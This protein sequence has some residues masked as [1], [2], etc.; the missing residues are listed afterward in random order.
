M[1]AKIILIVTFSAS[2]LFANA[3]V[4]KKIYYN[5]DWKIVKST[6]TVE[7]YRIVK[8]DANNKALDTIRNYYVTGE[9]E[10]K[11][12]GALY[13]DTM[14]EK[15]TKYTGLAR[16]YYKSGKRKYE[17]TR[18]K[19][20]S[21]LS[22]SGWY[23]DGKLR[24]TAPYVNGKEEG[25]EKWYYED[26]SELSE[27]PYVNDKKSGT[28][29]WYYP[30]GAVRSEVIYVNDLQEGTSKGYYPTG[31]LNDE[32]TYVK[33]TLV[34]ISKYYYKNGKLQAEVPHAKGKMDGTYKLYYES[35]KPMG[36][37]DY[38]NGK[39]NGYVILYWEN[40]ILKRR[41]KYEDGKFVEGKCYDSDGLAVQHYDY[42]VEG[43][44]DDIYTI[45]QQMPVFQGNMNEY[46][47]K[48]IKYPKKEQKKGIMGTV[49][50]NFIVEKDG[51]VSNAKVLR[52]VE[53]GPGLEE[54][55]LRVIS[56]MPKWTP[57]IQNG[58]TVRVSYNIP[59]RFVLN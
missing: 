30:H 27:T 28:G 9:V 47:S 3:Q 5:K 54:E 45:V 11:A 43:P 57:G 25:I 7:Y 41:D 56:H 16:G 38:V 40:K 53:G 15:N 39:L 51:T 42:Y 23:E 24:F 13:V 21:I 18:D 37:Y 4:E 19:S 35:G 58:L 46:L 20:S 8:L 59:I 32:S 12:D 26:G 2:F 36:T 6:D 17:V 34:G 22:Y 48:N 31:E 10:A 33:D 29:K 1:K 50:I 52:G 14:N 44:S 49:Y 55:A